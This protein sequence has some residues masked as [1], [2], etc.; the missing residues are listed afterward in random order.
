MTT[1]IALVANLIAWSKLNWYVSSVLTMLRSDSYRK[2]WLINIQKLIIFA[3]YE[4][5]NPR[6]EVSTSDVWVKAYTQEGGGI[7]PSAEPYF[8]EIQK[9]QKLI[10]DLQDAGTPPANTDALIEA[11]GK[12]SR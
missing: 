6:V 9:K 8:A 12:D 10:K 3:F 2:K 4:S 7:L 1:L 11:F 5:V